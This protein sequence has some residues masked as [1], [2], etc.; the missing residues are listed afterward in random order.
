M[1]KKDETDYDLICKKDEIF[2]LNDNIELFGS[3]LINDID[4][5]LLTQIGILIYHFNENDKSISLNYFY[6]ESLSTKKSLSQCYKK[7]FSK[8]TLPLLNYESIEYDGWVSEIKNNKKLLLKYGVELMK[9]A[10]ESHNLE[11]VDKIYKKCQSYFKQDFSN[12]I[13]LSIIILTIPLLNEKLS[14]IY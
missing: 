8:S 7:I 13:F 2:I 10:I 1:Q 6:K 5:I 12:K 4:I 9:F 3:Q 14:R 11:L